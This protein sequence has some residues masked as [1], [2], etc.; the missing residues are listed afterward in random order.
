MLTDALWLYHGRPLLVLVACEHKLTLLD[1]ATLE[2]R[3]VKY[4]PI[5]TGVRHIG[6]KD[7]WSDFWS[8]RDNEEGRGILAWTVIIILVFVV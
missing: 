1:P 3:R 8:G 7:E 2:L 5:G 4:E 6:A